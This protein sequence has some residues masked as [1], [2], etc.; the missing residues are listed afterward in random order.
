[1]ITDTCTHIDKLSKRKCYSKMSVCLLWQSI[2]LITI[3][4]NNVHEVDKYQKMHSMYS[5]IDSCVEETL[6]SRLLSVR[7]VI[8]LQLKLDKTLLLQ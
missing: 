7:S 4:L 1:M 2:Y 3:L 8:H 6:L 5:K